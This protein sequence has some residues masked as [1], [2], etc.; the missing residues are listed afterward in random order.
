MKITP[1]QLKAIVPNISKDSLATYVPLLNEILPKWEISTPQ[2]IQMF[3]AQV[4]HESGSFKY[5]REIASGNAYEGRQDLGNVF[6]GDGKKFKGKGLIQITGRSNHQSCSLALFG[7]NRLLTNPDI[8]ATP[9]YA[10]ESACWYWKTRGLN[11]LCD[12]PEDWEKSILRK[13]G[14]TKTYTKVQWITRKINGGLNGIG[15]RE[16]FY[17][18]AREALKAT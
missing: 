11:E 12:R 18:R 1:E 8:L 10:L 9:H 7:D 17:E 3:I 4:A 15:E 6:P 5:T 14:Q 2:R 13:D 16:E